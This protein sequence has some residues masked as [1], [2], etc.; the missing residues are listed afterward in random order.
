MNGN[1]KTYE[2]AWCPGCGDFGILESLKTA[3]GEMGKKPQEVLA[4]GGIGQAAKLPQYL[5]VNNFCGLH[6]RAIPAA[7][8]AKIANED[9]TVIV[10]TGDGDAYGEGGNHFIHNIRRNVDITLF[11]HD[12]RVYGLT[13][14]QASPTSDLGF[15]TGVQTDGNIDPPLNPVTLAIAAGCGFVARAYAGDKAHLTEIMKKAIAYR[16][17]SFVD[18]L[19]PCVSFN[20]VNTYAYFSKRIYHLDDAYDPSDKTAALKLA[21]EPED[22][23][24]LGVIYLEQRKTFHERNSVLQKGVPLIE[25][26]TDKSVL[27]RLV[28]RLG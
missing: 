28:E 14:G 20:K 11:V 21:M 10:T 8:A 12:N 26:R 5:S 27:D 16:G 9:L 23:I 7:V 17:F 15:V 25:Y 6:G 22:R 1:F 19:Q 13:K 18:I 4:V 3:L 2:T 24:A